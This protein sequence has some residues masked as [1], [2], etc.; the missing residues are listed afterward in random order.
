[1]NKP[2][3]IDIVESVTV[4]EGDTIKLSPSVSDPEGDEI[5]IEF[6]G[7]MTSDTKVTDFDDAGEYGVTITATDAGGRESTKNIKII[8]ENKNRRPEFLPGSFE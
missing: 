6:S 7:W 1:M 3:V 5:K 4:T 8:V 2:P